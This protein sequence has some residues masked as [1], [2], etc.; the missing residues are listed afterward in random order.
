MWWRVVPRKRP[1]LK[2]AVPIADGTL[3]AG[4]DVITAVDGQAVA[5]VD[6][7]SA[8]IST[9][10]V[11]DKVSL[12]ILRNGQSTT[13]QVTLEAWPANLSSGTTP[14]VPT[15]LQFFPEMA[16]GK[17]QVTETNISK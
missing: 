5:S 2:P 16:E 12:T 17:V 4:G 13:V 3:T 10:Q 1:A 15:T 8:Y 11:G 9:K 14:Q 7:L 6:E